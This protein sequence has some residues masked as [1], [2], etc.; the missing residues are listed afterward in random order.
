MQISCMQLNIRHNNLESGVKM[1]GLVHIITGN[2]KGKTT[3]A[4]GL[5]IRSFGVGKRVLIAQFLKGC[6]SAEIGILKNLGITVLRMDFVTKFT[7]QMTPDECVCVKDGCAKL[8]SE[9][10][11][12]SKSGR[13]DLIVVDEAMGALAMKGVALPTLCHMI[14]DKPTE[15]ELVFTGRNAPRELIERADYVSEIHAVKHPLDKGVKAREGIEF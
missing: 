5:A 11:N 1:K 14:D 7:W 6:E 2:G 15:L 9:V 13:W 10:L 3:S 4:I 8:M 12:E